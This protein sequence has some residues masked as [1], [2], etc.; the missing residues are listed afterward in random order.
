MMIVP[1]FPKHRSRR[2]FT[3]IELLVVVSI[4]AIL[5]SLLLPALA[6]ARES[7]RGVQCQSMLRQFGIVN[8]MYADTYDDWNL[9]I[10]GPNGSN[11]HYTP[12]LG[13]NY[14]AYWNIPEVR[15]WFGLPEHPHDESMVGAWYHDWPLTCPS[16][17][18]AVDLGYRVANAYA[19]N[20][21]GLAEAGLTWAD[22]FWGYRRGDV[23]DPSS[24]L[25]ITEANYFNTYYE[26]S[27]VDPAMGWDLY[28]HGL[29]FAPW[30]APVGMVQYR[31][32]EGANNLHFDGSVR[33]MPKQEMWDNHENWAL[34]NPLAEGAP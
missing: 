9:L 5:I 25:Q 23:V 28:G 34:W 18:V 10:K 19:V 1:T 2:A 12:G 30:N 14:A 21:T 16:A 11:P 33:R 8:A 20:R 13:F 24:K 31:H 17:E 32:M 3:L 4:I 26:P 29:F 6:S 7:A 15:T 22:D 27:R